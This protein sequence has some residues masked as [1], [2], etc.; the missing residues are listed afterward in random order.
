[1]PNAQPTVSDHLLQRLA[2]WEANRPQRAN[3]QSGQQGA[4]ARPRRESGDTTGLGA[5]RAE[6]AKRFEHRVAAIREIL[7]PDE[8]TQFDK[9]VAEAK[10]N[11]QQR[12]GRGKFQREGR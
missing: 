10:A 6:M 8:R 2:A 3:G 4:A 9:N 1:M 5:R 12:E 7:T 11:L